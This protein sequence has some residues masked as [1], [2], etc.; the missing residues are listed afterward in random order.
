[1]IIDNITCEND[2]QGEYI[3]EEYGIKFNINKAKANTFSITINNLNDFGLILKIPE[4]IN[5]Q[6]KK[7][8]YNLLFN[9]T[10]FLFY[11]KIDYN[12]KLIIF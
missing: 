7:L 1:M 5:D 6:T 11:I 4:K 3:L 10:F 9:P 2:I 8:L 12:L